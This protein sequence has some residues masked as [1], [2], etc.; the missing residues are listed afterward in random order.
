MK[1]YEG[2]ETAAAIADGEA[3]AGAGGDGKLSA[4]SF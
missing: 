2:F 4:G 3:N 1:E